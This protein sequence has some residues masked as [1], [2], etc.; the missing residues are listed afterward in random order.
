[1]IT[2]TRVAKLMHR[3]QTSASFNHL[4]ALF[5]GQML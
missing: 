5:M 4:G 1:M 2:A 3:A